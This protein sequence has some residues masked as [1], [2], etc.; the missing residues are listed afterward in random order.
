ME[1]TQLTMDSVFICISLA[2]PSQP[3][4][5]AKGTRTRGRANGVNKQSAVF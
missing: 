3:T 4:P 1:Q 5:L 2:A